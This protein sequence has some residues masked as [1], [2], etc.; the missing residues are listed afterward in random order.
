MMIYPNGPNF[1]FVWWGPDYEEWRIG[2]LEWKLNQKD[3]KHYSIHFG[4]LEFRWHRVLKN[5]E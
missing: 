4:P 2:F 3:F 1:Y 5:M